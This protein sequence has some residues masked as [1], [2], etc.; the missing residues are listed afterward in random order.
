MVTVPRRGRGYVGGH[1]GAP[2]V[3]PPGGYRGERHFPDHPVLG[4]L[5]AEPPRARSRPPAHPLGWI[6]L[7]AT[8][9]FSG[10][11]V[12]VVVSGDADLVF[13]TTMVALQVLVVAVIA[14]GMCVRRARVLAAVALTIAL[15]I[16]I[17]TA[18]AAGALI[19]PAVQEAGGSGSAPASP[20]LSYP[21]IKDVDPQAVLVA[22]SLEDVEQHAEQLSARIRER[23]SDEFGFTWTRIADADVRPERN[24]YG[25]ESLLQQYTS[26]T[27]RTDQPVREYEGKVAAMR[28]IGEVLAETREYYDLSP[29]NESDGAIDPRALESLYGSA[30]PRE[31][32]VWEYATQRYGRIA[33][34]GPSATLLYAT[35]TDLDNDPDG[36]FRAREEAERAPGEPL[37]GLSI[38]F[39]SPQLLSE[40]DRDAFEEGTR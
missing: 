12:A 20:E 30:D 6:A 27:W 24:G 32:A 11:L 7:L 16:N 15:L 28:V 39:L 18:G 21:G 19:G 36:R 34:R 14:A 25:G 1:A 22:P 29:L 35:L 26:P 8:V 5:V 10:L 2:P 33:P 40:A 13:G 37:E 23:L 9:L 4:D 31:Q 38:M 17:G 3:P